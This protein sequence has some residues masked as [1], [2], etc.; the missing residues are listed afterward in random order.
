MDMMG[1]R[2]LGVSDIYLRFD[3]DQFTALKQ[4]QK[5]IESIW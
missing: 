2:S 3:P 4:Y 5:S 1:H